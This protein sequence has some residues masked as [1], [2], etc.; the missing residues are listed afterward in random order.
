VFSAPIPKRRNAQHARHH[1]PDESTLDV[2]GV[3]DILMALAV[4]LDTGGVLCDVLLKRPVPI[5]PA[6]RCPVLGGAGPQPRSLLDLHHIGRRSEL[7]PILQDTWAIDFDE[8]KIA[9]IGAHEL[10]HVRQH[11]SSVRPYQRDLL[12]PWPAKMGDGHRL[13]AARE[14]Q[15]HFSAG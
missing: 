12:A 7:L 1:L 10:R 4:Y 11:V 3:V 8:V 13:L 9:S 14:R 2:R 15:K 5:F 6:T